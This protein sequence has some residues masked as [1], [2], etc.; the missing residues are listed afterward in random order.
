MTWKL[1]LEIFNPIVN[2][3]VISTGSF[4]P[5]DISVNQPLISAHLHNDSFWLATY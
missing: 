2:P 1:K 3:K 5:T 4:Q